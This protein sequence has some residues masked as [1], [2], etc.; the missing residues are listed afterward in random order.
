MSAFEKQTVAIIL[1]CLVGDNSVRSTARQWNV[2]P[3]TVATNGESRPQQNL[4]LA[5][6]ETEPLHPHGDAP[7][8]TADERFQQEVGEPSR[9]LRNLVRVFQF[10]SGS[11]DSALHPCDAGRDRGPHLERPRTPGGCVIWPILRSNV[12]I[13]VVF[14]RPMRRAALWAVSIVV[15]GALIGGTLA[16]LGVIDDSRRQPV[17]NALVSVAGIVFILIFA[18]DYFKIGRK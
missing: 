15:V 11:Q 5:R 2:E 18:A 17:I 10:L 16:Q 7:H 12:G 1:K 13:L 4:H 9:G 3:R 14:S 8:D 6:W